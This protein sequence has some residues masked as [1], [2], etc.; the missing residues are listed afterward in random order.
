MG[1]IVFKARSMLQIENHHTLWVWTQFSF[2]TAR[3]SSLR[4]LCFYRC[5]SV[6][7]GGCLPQCMLGDP[8]TPAKETPQGDPLPRRPPLQAHTKG[9]NW[10]GSGPGPHPRGKMRGIR[11]RHTPKGG[12]QGF[13]GIRTRLPPPLINYCCGRYASY[14]NA[15][16]LFEVHIRCIKYT[17]LKTKLIAV[18]SKIFG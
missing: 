14:W 9:G 17:S 16:L 18:I 2:I 5:L 6:H 11:S 15:F 8:P 7:R 4:R 12:I 1:Q 13:R 3:K 10:G